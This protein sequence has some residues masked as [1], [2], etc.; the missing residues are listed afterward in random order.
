[1]ASKT[2]DAIKL[3]LRLPKPLHK[4]LKQQARRNNVSLN[5]EIVNQLS[6]P[7]GSGI[8]PYLLKE[9]RADL[10]KEIPA[11]LGDLR[12]KMETLL[13]ERG[14]PE[15]LRFVI[16]TDLEAAK[17]RIA[18]LEDQVAHLRGQAESEGRVQ[19]TRAVEREKG[20][21]PERLRRPVPER[22]KGEEQK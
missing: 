1:M 5:T 4:R 19:D 22:E 15:P 11:A 7:K 6:P 2:A 3:V 13:R 9:I 21:E 16:E 8:T 17:T 18:A 20:E 14:L 10:L 12:G